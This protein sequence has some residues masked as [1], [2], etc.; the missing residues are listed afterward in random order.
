M[1]ILI[2]SEED[3]HYISLS[4]ELYNPEMS[5]P[6]GSRAASTSES[7]RPLLNINFKHQGILTG[8]LAS[9]AG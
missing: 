2:F 1:K 9:Y 6:D 5:T 4:K 7:D 8:L 3:I